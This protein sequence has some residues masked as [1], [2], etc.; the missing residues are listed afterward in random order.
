MSEEFY[1]AI[2]FIIGNGVKIIDWL[3]PI[4]TDTLEEILKALGF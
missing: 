4:A 2:T 3:S 1:N